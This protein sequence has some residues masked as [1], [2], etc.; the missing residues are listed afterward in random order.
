MPSRA[1]AYAHDLGM[2][3]ILWCYL[4][5]NAFKK[6]KDYHLSADLTGQANHL[7]VTIEAYIIKQKLA[8]NNG[9]Y[10]ALNMA[11]S[12]YGKFDKR[13]YTDLVS[14]HPIDLCR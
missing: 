6:N 14:D 5:N 10:Q 11:D 13:I 7:G 3:T 2:G 12:S 4:R 1:F 8:Q 9:G